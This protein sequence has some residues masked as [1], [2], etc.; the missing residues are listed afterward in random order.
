MPQRPDLAGARVTFP[1]LVRAE[2]I[3]LRSIRSTVWCYLVLFVLSILM[4]VLPALVV[5]RSGT[6][7]TGVDADS[8]VATIN[9]ISIHLTAL[10][11]AV[12]GV[13]IVSGEYGTGQIRSTFI[14]DPRRLGATFAKAL[15]LATTT[16]VISAASVWI[17]AFASAPILSS[18][19]IDVNLGHSAV[20]LPILGG[21]V[22]V[23][24]VALLAFGIGTLV[25][26]TAGGIA[27][28]LGLLLV[29]PG[30]LSAI[31]VLTHTQWLLDVNQFLPSQAGAQLFAFSG[32]AHGVVVHAGGG[33]A[34]GGPA[35]LT[36]PNIQLDGWQGFWVL[37]GEVVAVGIVAFT[38]TKRRDA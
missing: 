26:A 3:K 9:T 7:V 23:T 25:R 17:G 29:V 16:F 11:V 6:A 5:N 8:T 13:L 36:S 28:T 33:A 4:S 20:F 31:G 19:H 32:D 14:A 38:L 22:Y 15:V 37:L 27:I 30:I 34:A 21:S 1:R 10:V 24:L 18:R 2:W 12:L 35:D